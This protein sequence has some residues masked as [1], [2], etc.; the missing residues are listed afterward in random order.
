MIHDL[1]RNYPPL[2]YFNLQEFACPTIEGSGN[3]MCPIFVRKLDEAREIANT[4]FKINS[5]YRSPAH[6]KAVGGVSNS[7]HT[8]IPCNASD[9]AVKDSRQR[10]LILNSL[11]KVG[12]T[13]FGIGKNFIHVDSDIDKKS[14]NVIW[15]YY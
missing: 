1:E 12:F 14:P 6:N 3:N 5:G 8:N 7:S 9:I 2:K 10:Y 4:S 13:R 11:M 15:Q